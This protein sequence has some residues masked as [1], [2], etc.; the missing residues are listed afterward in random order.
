MAQRP[1]E[2]VR[3]R[4]LDIDETVN[5]ISKC[6]TKPDQLTTLLDSLEN[7]RQTKKLRKTFE[8][9]TSPK[10]KRELDSTHPTTPT[11]FLF[12]KLLVRGL[13]QLLPLYLGNTQ[14]GITLFLQNFLFK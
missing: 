6:K 11:Q 2:I 12:K 13:A 3:E 7:V 14:L 4:W 10:V 1:W 5:F 9:L 8:Q